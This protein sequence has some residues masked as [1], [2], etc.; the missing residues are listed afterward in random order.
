MG[1]IATNEHF[2]MATIKSSFFYFQDARFSW[3]DSRRPHAQSALGGSSR[4]A[5]P[6]I[7]S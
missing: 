3:A 2:Y 6:G 5:D 4:I 1:V 7:L